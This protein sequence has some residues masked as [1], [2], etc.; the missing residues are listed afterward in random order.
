MYKPA[1]EVPVERHSAFPIAIN[2]EQQVIFG[3][4]KVEEMASNIAGHVY[5]SNTEQT[6]RQVAVQSVQIAR[7][8]LKLTNKE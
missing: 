2:E 6:A 3:L 7:E 4:T 8:I 1:N 5:A